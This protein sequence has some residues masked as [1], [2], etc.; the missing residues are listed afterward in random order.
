MLAGD[1]PPARLPGDRGAPPPTPPREPGAATGTPASIDVPSRAERAPGHDPVVVRV[2][3]DEIHASEVFGPLLFHFR[4]VAMELLLKLAGDAVVRAEA[5]RLDVRVPPEEIDAGVASAIDELRRRVD[6]EFPGADFERFFAEQLRTTRPE[7][8]RSLRRFVE[9]SRLAALLVRYDELRSDRV[10][11][12]EIVARDR[13]HADE[14]L[15]KLRDGAEFSAL[16]RAESVAASRADG[17]R[18]PPLDRESAHPARDAAFAAAVGTVGGPVE[19]RRGGDT[20]WLLFRVI[21]RIPGRDVPFRVAQKEVLDGLRDRPIARVEYEAY[22][23]KAARR[24][25]IELL[26]LPR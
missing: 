24:Y 15:E 23:R 7:Y 22:L 1:R 5:E 2:A 19:D 17:G 11:I 8:E 21:E 9:E 20:A 26:G 13:P 3:G 16:A 10:A 6:A 25:P 14:L 4:D 18:I 12:R